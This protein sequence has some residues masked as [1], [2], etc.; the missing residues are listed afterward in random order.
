MDAFGRFSSSAA[1]VAAVLVLGCNEELAGVEGTTSLRV[2]LLEPQSYGTSDDRLL[3]EQRAVTLQVEALDEQGDLDSSFSGEVDIFAHYLGSLTPALDQGRAL[4]SVQI[5]AGVSDEVTLELPRVFGPTFLWVEDAGDG[6]TFA[7]GTSDTLW[8]RD[9]F[10]A[11]VS[12]PAD[13][14]ALDALERSPLEAKQ[15]NVTASRYG[16]RGRLVVTGIYPQGYTLADVQCADAAGT[17]P[18]TTGD[19]DS[20]FVFSFSRPEDEQFRR[21]KVGQTVTRLTGAV[22]EFNGLTEVNFPQSFVADPEPTPAQVPAPV[23][24]DPA[25]LMSR[26]EM[27]RNEAA[28]IAIENATVCPLDDDWQTFKQWKLDVGFGC[29]RNS[30][31]IITAGQVAEFMPSDYVGAVIPRVVGTLR[32]INIGSF[33]VWI[34]YPRA[35]EDLDL[36]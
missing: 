32:P 6:A 7:T 28:L 11:D 36:P 34:V 10:L 35:V 13:E 29:D 24:L 4:G 16:A 2:T 5:E 14:T 23:I 31:N 9:P 12:Q 20:I 18:C 30:I 15:I 27:E 26:V 17:P 8:Y 33:N 25:W 21:M 22:S 1:L 19:Y 3:D